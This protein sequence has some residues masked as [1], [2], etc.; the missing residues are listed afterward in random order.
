MKIA[1]YLDTREEA[2]RGLIERGEVREHN[3]PNCREPI[4]NYEYTRGMVTAFTMVR[5]FIN[6]H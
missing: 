4:R 6:A 1:E 3:C 2:Y 5:E